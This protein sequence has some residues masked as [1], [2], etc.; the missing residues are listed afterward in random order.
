MDNMVDRTTQQDEKNALW[1]WFAN[2]DKRAPH[3]F[4]E[5]HVPTHAPAAIP[6]LPTGN[7]NNDTPGTFHGTAGD[8]RGPDGKGFYGSSGNDVI[9]GHGG[10]D[11]IGGEAGN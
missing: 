3:Y 7:R 5:L 2:G 6:Q 1:D 8:D 4:P 10:N 9:Y 11:S